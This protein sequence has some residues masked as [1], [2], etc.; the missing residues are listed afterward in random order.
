MVEVEEHI[1]E[2]V[3]AIKWP[4]GCDRF[5]IKPDR[6][7]GRGEGNGV[8][9]I[10]DALVQLLVA[11]G[12][13]PEERPRRFDALYRFGR[14]EGEAFTLEWETGNVSSSHRSINRIALA[15]MDGFAIGGVIVLPSGNM[16]KYLTDRIGNYPELRPYIPLWK[17]WGGLAGF[18]YLGIVVVEHDDVSHDVD[19]IPKGT[20]G[21]ALM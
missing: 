19:R 4:P 15:M 12:W 20:D 10:K 7:K 9:P 21:R 13:I 18:G 1:R 14:N 11:K 2:A 5:I 3:E 8:K 16:Y 6:G 17:Q